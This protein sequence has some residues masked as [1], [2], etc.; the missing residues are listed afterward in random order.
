L[1]S[2]TPFIFFR[3]T[4]GA[5]QVGP[6]ELPKGSSVVVSP[7]ITHHMPE[8]WPE[9]NKFKPERWL[10]TQKPGTYEY[11][12]FNA[13]PRT[14]VGFAFAMMAMKI[15]AAMVLQRYRF[16][17][18]PGAELHYKARATILGSKDSIRMGLERQGRSRRGPLNPLRG[19]VHELVDLAA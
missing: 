14:C 5:V 13:G 19:N 3:R 7:L 8:L 9:P 17:S 18:P 16:S 2:P 6:Y 10:G 15:A 4:T 12:P 11:L 1:L